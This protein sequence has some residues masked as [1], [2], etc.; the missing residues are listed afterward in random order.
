MPSGEMSEMQKKKKCFQGNKRNIRTVITTG[1]NKS[2]WAV[3]VLAHVWEHRVRGCLQPI[4][5]QQRQSRKI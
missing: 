1:G 2:V 5:K 3:R 4:G